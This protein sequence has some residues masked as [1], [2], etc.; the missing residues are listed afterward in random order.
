MVY[1]LHWSNEAVS[2]L[3]EILEYLENKWTQKEVNN[4]KSKLGKQLDLIQQ[5]PLL[6]PKS[7]IKKELR[8]AVLSS[9]TI[10]FYQIIGKDIFLA[11][12]FVTKKDIKKLK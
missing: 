12:L 11:H 9:Q 6:F 4:F 10:V 3:E 8:K 1:K 5:N 7:E 2:N